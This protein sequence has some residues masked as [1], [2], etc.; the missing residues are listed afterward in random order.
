M[1]GV[2][3][4]VILVPQK[5]KTKQNK[6]KQ[7]CLHMWFNSIIRYK[8]SLNVSFLCV[9]KVNNSIKFHFLMKGL[10]NMDTSILFAFFQIYVDPSDPEVSF[11]SNIT[12][13][14]F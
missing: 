13:L 6:T 10:S 3:K 8:I 7:N 5:N 4:N 14:T 1:I 9:L 2:S 11:R 12:V